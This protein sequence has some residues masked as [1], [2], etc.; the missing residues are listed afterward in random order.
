MQTAINTTMPIAKAG[1]LADL[2]F[3]EIRSYINSAIQKITYT[4]TSA[5]A[6]TTITVNGTAYN[7]NSGAETKTTTELAAALVVLINAGEGTTVTAS[8]VNNVVTIV[9]DTITGSFTSAAT[10]NCSE[11]RV[12][13]AP[14][15]IGFGVMVCI[16]P[17]NNSKCKLPAV[18]TDITGTRAIGFTFADNTK[19]ESIGYATNEMV[20]VV[21]KGNI[22][23][24]AEEAVAPGDSVHVRYTANGTGK[25]TL[26]AVRNDTDSST[27]AVLAGAEVLDYN[28]TTG[29]ALIGLNRI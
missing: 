26:G 16:D 29:L 23:V 5:N 7:T 18:A 10:L 6:S 28:S 15:A 27:C 3:N 12:V 4:V 13:D 11:T 9:S 24:T 8:N 20:A 25:T 2:G 14:G 21:K 17:A 19:E 22:W 1:Q